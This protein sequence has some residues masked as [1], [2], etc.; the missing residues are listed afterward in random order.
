[1]S[2]SA[3]PASHELLARRLDLLRAA[4]AARGFPRN[5]E[6]AGLGLVSASAL[7][8]LSLAE[9]E[10]ELDRVQVTTEAATD[11][12]APLELAA[13]L[14]L[15]FAQGPQ[16]EGN[17]TRRALAQQLNAAD[18]PAGRLAVVWTFVVMA[19]DLD[20]LLARDVGAALNAVN[21]KAADAL[22]LAARALTAGLALT[23]DSELRAVQADLA[24]MLTECI[25]VGTIAG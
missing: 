17:E 10:R 14:L 7:L 24:R 16:T 20:C 18:G 6:A 1:M 22:S 19:L 25:E 12:T 23:R 13:R 5:P 3:S 11:E 4:L 2:D 8:A 9:S 21:A 15:P